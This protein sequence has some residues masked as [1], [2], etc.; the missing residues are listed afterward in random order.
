ML[1]SG[2]SAG[3]SFVNNLSIFLRSKSF[4]ITGTKGAGTYLAY[5]AYQSIPSKN[6]WRLISSTLREP[7]LS[8]AYEEDIELL[9]LDGSR[10]YLHCAY[11]GPV[12][13]LLP[14]LKTQVSFQCRDL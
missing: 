14:S 5:I 10:N 8:L 3:F 13:D 9:I 4:S 1:V 2:V 11:K 7:S 12:I 6:M